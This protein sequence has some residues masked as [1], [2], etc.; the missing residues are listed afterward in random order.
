MSGIVPST[1]FYDS[2]WC[3]L[4]SRL[5]F[6]FV[7]H[8]NYAPFWIIEDFHA[9][10]NRHRITC[11]LFVPISFSEDTVRNNKYNNKNF[12]YKLDFGRQIVYYPIMSCE[13]CLYVCFFSVLPCAL[14]FIVE[15][16]GKIKQFFGSCIQNENVTE[17]GYDVYCYAS[18]IMKNSRRL[19]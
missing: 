1:T 16:K 4:L 8:L 3:K 17:F 9:C 10:S 2:W 13:F 5:V 6:L 7:F 11:E 15:T 18:L 19:A 12:S 14:L